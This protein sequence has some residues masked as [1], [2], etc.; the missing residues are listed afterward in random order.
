VNLGDSGQVSTENFIYCSHEAP[1]NLRTRVK[2]QHEELRAWVRGQ[3]C[4]K[5]ITINAQLTSVR[6]PPVY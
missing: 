4:S 1:A 3:I 2:I 6:N 5:G